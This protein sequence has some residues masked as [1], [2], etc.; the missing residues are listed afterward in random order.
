MNQPAEPVD[1][2]F[3]AAADGSYALKA[4][5]VQFEDRDVDLSL[6]DLGPIAGRA[7]RELSERQRMYKSLVFSH[8]ADD[9]PELESPSEC[10][11]RVGHV[12][13]ALSMD[14]VP[15]YGIH[16]HRKGSFLCVSCFDF[17]TTITV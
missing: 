10:S 3:F 12:C 2:D 4:H 7:E 5:P 13:R 17:L 6:E 14:S 1:L 16:V 15:L 11:C 9:E 8:A